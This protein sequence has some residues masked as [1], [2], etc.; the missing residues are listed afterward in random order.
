MEAIASPGPR[1]NLPPVPIV[2]TADDLAL[3]NAAL[4]KRIDA[5][6]NS[7]AWTEIT[8]DE[9]ALK[10]A[11][12][13]EQARTLYIDAKAAH[14]ERKKPFLEAGTVIDS[15]WRPRL[16]AI[17]AFGVRLKGM[18]D[19]RRKRA[20]EAARKEQ[21]RLNEEAEKK[22]KAAQ[23]TL[24]AAERNPEVRGAPAEVVAERHF[25]RSAELQ[26]QAELTAPKV[27]VS[28]SG[29][30][31]GEKLVWKAT[32]TNYALAAGALL[33]LAPDKLKETIEKEVQ[34]LARGGMRTI[35]GVTIEQVAET[36]VSKR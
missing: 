17:E 22:R 30:K 27:L 6:L 35:D 28:D 31:I 3:E 26:R 24:N 14:D 2:P 12:T 34:R 7:I 33:A 32:V 21:E 11:E 9:Q 36:T 20:A 25:D 5:C 29:V 23:L 1:H 19:L 16:G 18:I 15:W 10:A 8:T 4:T 13:V